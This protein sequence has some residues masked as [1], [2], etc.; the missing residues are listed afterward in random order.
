MSFVSSEFVS[1]TIETRA[2]ADRSLTLAI[3]FQLT[4]LLTFITLS[5]KPPWRLS[6]DR[7][8]CKGGVDF[9]GGGNFSIA[10][11]G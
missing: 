6:D 9:L 5:H 8:T 4:F 3:E 11:H 7:R 1:I 2:I 10:S